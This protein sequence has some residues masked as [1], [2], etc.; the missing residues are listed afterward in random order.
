L[1]WA[2]R[3]R[4]SVKGL[5]RS[6]WPRLLRNKKRRN[7]KR[8]LSRMLRKL[9]RRPKRWPRR[10]L[11]LR[12]KER[13]TRLKPK[14]RPSDL[15]SEGKQTRSWPRMNINK[16]LLLLPTNIICTRLAIDRT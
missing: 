5:R 14:R 3:W 8:R 12:N 7:K 2:K 13:S 16:R 4:R 6:S 11:K 10:R 15:P 9:L 1:K